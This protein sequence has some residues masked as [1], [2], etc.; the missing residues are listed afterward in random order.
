M[1]MCHH[2]WARQLLGTRCAATGGSAGRSEMTEGVGG[3]FRR[4]G[5]YVDLYLLCCT[6]EINTALESSYPPIKNKLEKIK[7]PGCISKKQNR[8]SPK[9]PL[10]H[11]SVTLAILSVAAWMAFRSVQ[12]L[13]HVRLFVTPWTAACQASLSITNSQR[14]LKLSVH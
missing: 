12:L 13:S 7:T 6:A 2:G 8:K 9:L 11:K 10:K 5:I 1:Y 14:L 3:S 4:E